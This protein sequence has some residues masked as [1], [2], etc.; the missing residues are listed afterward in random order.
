MKNGKGWEVLASHQTLTYL[1]VIQSST[2]SDWEQAGTLEM[3]ESS[4]SHIAAEDR[5]SV[6]AG[7]LQ[8][9]PSKLPQA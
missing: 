1:L 9:P 6:A 7:P 8:S 4:T 3:R 2:H 5:L